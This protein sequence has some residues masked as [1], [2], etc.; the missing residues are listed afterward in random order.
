MKTRS[1]I[2]SQVPS[3]VA[4]LSSEPI[5]SR[6]PQFLP[7]FLCKWALPNPKVVACENHDHLAL[8]Y[9]NP[10][11]Q[12][13]II[14]P[15]LRL[16]LE[17]GEK[18]VY[19][20]DESTPEAVIAAM[21]RYGIDVG[22]AT[23]SG[24]LS[25]I[26]KSHAYLKNGDFDPD[27]MIDFLGQAVEDAKREGFPA[28]RASGEMT[29]ALGPAGNAHDRLIEY[30]C[31]LKAFFSDYDMSGICQY[32]RRRFSAQTLMHVIHTHP[33]V[34]FRGEVCENPFY[35]PAE[36]IQGQAEGMGEAVR[37]LL[38]SMAENTRLR[39]ELAAE[40]EALLRS[41]KAVSAGRMA[42]I[43]AHELN[44]PIEAMTNF[45]FLL[46]RE[47]LPASARTYLDAMG[48]ELN[49]VCQLAKRTLEALCF[50]EA[51]DETHLS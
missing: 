14:V 5:A 15:Y 34:V 6:P 8:I 44:N 32:N 19:I 7:S 16:G 36:I 17:R 47:D 46:Q 29:W 11:E 49:R 21:E 31:K 22:A 35:I 23:A 43:V 4:N 1:L 41:E 12:L 40:C 30:E 27:W 48:D 25:I 50:E 33:R 3:T 9:D 13:D 45:Y 26:T 10:D 37:R 42:A 2:T 38:D 28:V 20:Y 51:A 18:S 39:R 24:A